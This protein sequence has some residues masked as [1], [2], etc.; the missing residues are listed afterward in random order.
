MP[1]AANE[2]PHCSTERSKGKYG[3]SFLVTSPA[4]IKEVFHGCSTASPILSLSSARVFA[5]MSRVPTSRVSRILKSASFPKPS[6]C[7]T[8]YS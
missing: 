7:V 8:L 4:T 5:K 6:A 1:S 2:R 3:S